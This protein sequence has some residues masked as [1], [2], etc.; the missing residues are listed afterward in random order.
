MDD[1]G[2]AVRSRRTLMLGLLA[3]DAEKLV[4]APAALHAGARRASRG[5]P[6]GFIN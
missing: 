1:R 2:R 5:A 4:P 6:S 3:R